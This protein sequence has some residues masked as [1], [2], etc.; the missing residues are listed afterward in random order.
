[1]SL[2]RIFFQL[3]LTQENHSFISCFSMPILQKMINHK[4]FTKTSLFFFKVEDDNDKSLLVVIIVPLAATF[5]VLI[6]VMIVIFTV[7]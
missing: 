2:W 1:M 6:V 7:K 5:I 4:S 3:Q